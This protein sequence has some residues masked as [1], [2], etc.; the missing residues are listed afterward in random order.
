MS[1][2]IN[3]RITE[4]Y[5]KLIERPMQVYEIFKD[6]FG[7]EF[8]DIQGIPT[9]DYYITNLE[10]VYGENSLRDRTDYDIREML[11]Y[12]I[13]EIF[14][15][16]KF[17]EVTVTNEN[18][19]S[20]DIWGLYAKVKITRDGKNVGG[21]TL[22]RSVYNK[23]QFK[24]NYLHSHVSK[25]PIGDLTEFLPPCLGD[26]PIRNT[27][28]L[29]NSEFDEVRWQLFCLE[30]SK[31]VTV[32]SLGGGPYRRMEQLGESSYNKTDNN[33]GYLT[34]S[35]TENIMGRFNYMSSS[36]LHGFIR[37][38]LGRNKLKFYYNGGWNI[39]MSRLNMIVLFSN[40]FIEWYNGE[41]AEGRQTITFDKFL[42]EGSLLRG[43]IKNNSIYINKKSKNPREDYSR[44]VGSF[45]CKFKGENVTL[46]IRDLDEGVEEGDNDSTF[47]N[48]NIVEF[49]YLAI[50][51]VINFEYGNIK[52]TDNSETK[53][54]SLKKKHFL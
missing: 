21:F 10:A 8:V 4:V 43:I 34:R 32:E 9:I 20:I 54:R 1:D 6:F 24:N 42:K 13:T 45:I 31:Y 14:I 50:I 2:E 40:E 38:F 29:L 48:H 12:H 27:I 47:L 7:E 46:T 44:Y 49:I 16:V 28:A 36:I 51:K 33:W 35:S 25:I 39:S 52:D 26:G 22:N 5:N 41:Y 37:W 3:N 23:F 30:L 17:P 53:I 19:R 18:D 11:L 15:L